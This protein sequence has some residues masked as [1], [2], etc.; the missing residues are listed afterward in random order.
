MFSPSSWFSASA[1]PPIG[2]LWASTPKR[3]SLTMSEKVVLFSPDWASAMPPANRSRPGSRAGTNAWGSA[4]LINSMSSKEPSPLSKSNQILERKMVRNA[5][6]SR[7]EYAPSFGA[8]REFPQAVL[9]RYQPEQSLR[10]LHQSYQGG[11]SRCLR[12][13]RQASRQVNR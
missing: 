4:S 13:T 2:I 3:T 5:A 7:N 8:F 10:H 12:P 6:L 9:N 1:L 11:R